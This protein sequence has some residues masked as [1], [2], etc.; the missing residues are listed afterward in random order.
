MERIPLEKLIV[1][2][3][4]KE[5]PEFY[6]SLRFIIVF[7][8]YASGSFPELDE[9]RPQPHT[10]FKIH[11]NIIVHRS[12]YHGLQNGLFSLVFPTRSVYTFLISSM[13]AIRPIHL[14]LLDQPN[15]ILWIVQILKH[16]IM[17]FSPS[18]ISSLLGPNIYPQLLVLKHLRSILFPQ[19][20]MVSAHTKQF[21][22]VIK[23]LDRRR[24]DNGFWSE[25]L[26]A[27]PEFL[28]D[29]DLRNSFHRL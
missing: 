1:V 5:F 14:I 15:I 10:L 27:F 9:S 12:I 7:T 19:D 22:L 25:W 29:K 6:G 23:S 20:E 8:S 2:Q 4:M 3:L 21:I 16:L 11:I 13:L 28:Y 18:V 24:V 17:Q 26:R